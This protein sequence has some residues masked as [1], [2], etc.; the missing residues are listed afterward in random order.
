MD[1]GSKGLVPDPDIIVVKATE[2][3]NGDMAEWL[4]KGGNVN[5]YVI[6]G[7]DK[8]GAFA[9]MA[10]RSSQ[11]GKQEFTI[12]FYNTDSDAWGYV[13][14]SVFRNLLSTNVLSAMNPW[15]RPT[16]VGWNIKRTRI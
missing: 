8:D 13:H 3:F 2:Y 16:Y 4:T 15:A 14:S 10:V 9:A 7:R 12:C 1:K 5:K 11:I 6:L